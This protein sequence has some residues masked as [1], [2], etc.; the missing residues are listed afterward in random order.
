MRYLFYLLFFASTLF[1]EPPK[2]VVFDFGGV[3]G[4]VNRK[5]MLEFL[6]DSLGHSM[7]KL[8]KDL[9]NDQ[10]YIALTK[11]ANYWEAYSKNALGDHWSEAFEERKREVVTLNVEVIAIIEALK[12]QGIQVAL[13]SNTKRNRARF[14]EKMGHYGL[15][16][17]ILLSC[18]LGA[19]KPERAIYEELIKHLNWEKEECLFIDNSLE[20][21]GAARDFGIDSIHFQSAEGLKEEL[22]KRDL[23]I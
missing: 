21:V 18:Y 5:P 1:S 2:V 17:P 20:N 9:S 12:E 13:L 23:E 8:K 6:S 16:D 10:L 7:R 22:K 3:V 19:K 11:S 4:N 14:I 15:F